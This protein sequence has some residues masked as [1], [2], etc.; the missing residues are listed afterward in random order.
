MLGVNWGFQYYIPRCLRI[1]V[2]NKPDDNF[3]APAMKRPV[4]KLNKSVQQLTKRE[5]KKTDLYLAG[6]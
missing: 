6:R 4:S 3:P 5:S 1:P 2:L